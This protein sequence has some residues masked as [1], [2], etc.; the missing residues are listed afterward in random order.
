MISCAVIFGKMALIGTE[1]GKIMYYCTE[2]FAV[3]WETVGHLEN[4]LSLA[5]NE[6]TAVSASI[7]PDLCKFDVLKLELNSYLSHFNYVYY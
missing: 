3:K 7:V 5:L 6:K 1:G 4:V 2:T